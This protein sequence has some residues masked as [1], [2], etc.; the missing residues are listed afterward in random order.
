MRAWVLL[1]PL[2]FALPA[3]AQRFSKVDGN[4]L[5]QMCETRA[6]APLRPGLTAPPGRLQCEAYI[7]GIADAIAAAGP[8]RAAACIPLAVTTPQLVAVVLKDLRARPEATERP[9]GALATEALARAF[10]CAH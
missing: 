9:A 8:G 6:P 2:A 10:P 5:L 1:L 4:R 3:H 7:S